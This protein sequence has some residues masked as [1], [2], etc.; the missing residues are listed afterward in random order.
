MKFNET[1][2]NYPEEKEFFK[3]KSLNILSVLRAYPT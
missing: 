1:G 2:S 3:S